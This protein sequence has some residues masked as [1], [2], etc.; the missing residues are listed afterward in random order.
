MVTV[1]A[2]DDQAVF[3]HT[4]R[5]LIAATRGFQQVAE[6]DSGE[7]ALRL[8][9]ELHPDLVLVDVR[10]PG[11]DGIETARR[12]TDQDRGAVVVLVSLEAMVDLPATVAQ[13]GAATHMRKQDLSPR[14]LRALW[15]AHGGRRHAAEHA[16]ADPAV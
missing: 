8:A 13:S 5:E 4:A 7:Q 15:S 9:A 11:M 3:R 16:G 12:L 10:M 1:L 6:A 14:A 2:V